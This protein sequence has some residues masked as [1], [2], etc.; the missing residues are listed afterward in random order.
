M[1]AGAGRRGGGGGLGWGRQVDA[2]R[3]EAQTGGGVCAVQ[4]GKAHK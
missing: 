1:G 2:C 4:V 3:R